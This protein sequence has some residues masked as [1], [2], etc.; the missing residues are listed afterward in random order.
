[1]SDRRLKERQVEALEKIAGTLEVMT[2]ALG[3]IRSK[4]TSLTTAVRRKSQS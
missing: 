1:M 2:Q 4:L 3:E